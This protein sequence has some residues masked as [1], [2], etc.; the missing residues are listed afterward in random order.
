MY[1][2][3]ASKGCTGHDCGNGAPPVFDNIVAQ[4]V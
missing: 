1:L 3:H 4:I 2:I